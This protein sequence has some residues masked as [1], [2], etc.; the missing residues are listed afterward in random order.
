MPALGRNMAFIYDKRGMGMDT[1]DL[2]NHRK[3]ITF[4][5]GLVR[6]DAGFK[7]QRTF[8]HTWRGDQ[9]RRYRREIGCPKFVGMKTELLRL[10]RRNG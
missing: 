8:Q 6:L 3:G 2:H 5:E 9:M 4:T 10:M 7:L 1:H